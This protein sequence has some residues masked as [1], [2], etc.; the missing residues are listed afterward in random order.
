[1]KTTSK[2]KLSPRP[3]GTKKCR[4]YW[5]LYDATYVCNWNAD[6]GWYWKKLKKGWEPTEWHAGHE[7]FFARPK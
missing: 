7:Y 5:Q 6:R 2:P 4:H 3:S 1:M